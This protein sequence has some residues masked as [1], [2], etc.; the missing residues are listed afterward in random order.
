VNGF[1]LGKIQ[2]IDNIVNKAGQVTSGSHSLM[3]GGN[4]NDCVGS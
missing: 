1:Y 2:L 3:F 4:S